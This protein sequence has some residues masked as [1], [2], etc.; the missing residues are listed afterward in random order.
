[1]SVHLLLSSMVAVY[2]FL[3][4]VSWCLGQNHKND[5][6][7]VMCRT[8]HMLIVWWCAHGASSSR[9]SIE[10]LCV[11]A[12]L[13]VESPRHHRVAL[14]SSV[15]DSLKRLLTQ[16]LLFIGLVPHRRD[17][18]HKP[19]RLS[20]YTPTHSVWPNHSCGYWPS[21]GS[22]GTNPACYLVEAIVKS[23]QNPAWVFLGNVVSHM[24]R[25]HV[26]LVQGINDRFVAARYQQVAWKITNNKANS[27]IFY[28]VKIPCSQN[29]MSAVVSHHDSMLISHSN[30]TCH[31]VMR[32]WW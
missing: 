31:H 28:G 12:T 1:M 3:A 15:V 25:D 17:G 22:P 11:S 23:L 16:N 21:S 6:C 26:L 19:M 27:G 5:D 24:A 9:M 2:I 30:S 10:W 20:W 7:M 13:S 4:L 32:T 14:Q 18:P 29:D 8:H